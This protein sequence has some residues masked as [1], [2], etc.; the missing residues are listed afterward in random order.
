MATTTFVAD[1]GAVFAFRTR[2]PKM[3][4]GTA[5]GVM[6]SPDGIK[7]YALDPRSNRHSRDRSHG[8]LE[9]FTLSI[10]NPHEDIQLPR[11]SE[12]RYVRDLARGVNNTVEHGG[13]VY[14][15]ESYDFFD[16]NIV[17]LCD[18]MPTDY[19]L[20]TPSGEKI[21]VI[22]DSWYLDGGGYG[23]PEFRIYAGTEKPLQQLDPRPYRDGS[24][25]RSLLF[26]GMFY[27]GTLTIP[28]YS[29]ELPHPT[30]QQ[31]P[32]VNEVAGEYLPSARVR[33][34]APLRN[35]GD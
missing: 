23:H 30:S 3:V 29:L 21:Y 28:D 32:T 24:R 18:A 2:E 15:E 19:F 17:S 20:Q 26:D 35:L 34:Y 33:D 1:T 31:A 4:P 27:R 7:F 16:Y 6:W 12:M 5:G 22:N 13:V 9:D 10:Y 8:N 11:E 14:S 25:A